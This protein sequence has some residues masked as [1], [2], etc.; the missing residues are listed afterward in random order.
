MHSYNTQQSH[1]LLKEYGRNVQLMVKN[2]MAIED[3]EKRKQ[4]AALL[5]ELMKMLIQ[6]N[7]S[8][9]VNIDINN[10]VWDDLYIISGF[11]LDVEGPFPKPDPKKIWAKPDKMRYAYAMPKLK[12]Y[13]KNVEYLINKI[14]KMEPGEDKDNAVIYAGRL[15]KNFYQFY[16]KDTLDDKVIKEQLEFLSG[17]E[18][19]VDLDKVRNEN[20]FETTAK[21][22]KVQNGSFPNNSINNGIPLVQRPQNKMHNNNNNNNL[23]RR[24]RK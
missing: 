3:S 16:S 19:T 13:G 17:K 14:K 12:H 23:R 15:M 18:L 11:K 20:L 24:R 22:R 6:P 1:I 2:L 10:K 5:V 8:K 7:A 4:Q 9:D 21:D